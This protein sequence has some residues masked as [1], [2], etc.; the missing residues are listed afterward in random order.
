M[1]I[2]HFIVL[3]ILILFFLLLNNIF[4][5]NNLN[6]IVIAFYVYS[7]LTIIFFYYVLKKNQIEFPISFNDI[8]TILKSRFLKLQ[9]LF[10]LVLV[11][12]LSLIIFNPSEKRQLLNL[13]SKKTVDA[14]KK[15]PS[16]SKNLGAIFDYTILLKEGD[17]V[18]V[19]ENGNK[20]VQIKIYIEGSQKSR[21][22]VS[23][24]KQDTLSGEWELINYRI[25]KK[26]EN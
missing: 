21:Y 14:I 22:V 8:K 7:I 17:F 1:K 23:Q 20:V 16:D 25:L 5:Y 19:N 9:G 18:Q 6:F 15:N 2:V 11:L 12:I 24:L 13:L 10:I 3:A 4:V 26:G